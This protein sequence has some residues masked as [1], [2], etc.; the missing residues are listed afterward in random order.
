MDLH[1]KLTFEHLA[2]LESIRPLPKEERIQ[3]DPHENPLFFNELG[4]Y[5]TI[6]HQVWSYWMH[7]LLPSKRKLDSIS[8][9][10][11]LE[12]N[13]TITTEQYDKHVDNNTLNYPFKVE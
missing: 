10:E 11:V 7:E 8:W 4:E 5:C 12:E 9:E 6:K 1:N 3:L 2:F 13:G